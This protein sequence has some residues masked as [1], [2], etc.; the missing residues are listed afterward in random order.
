MSS[1]EE[2]FSGNASRIMWDE[3][4]SLDATKTIDDVRD[5][6]FSVCCQIQ[7][8]ESKYDDLIKALTKEPT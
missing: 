5:V 3:I 4:N 2:V 7:V 1:T 6:L 8:L